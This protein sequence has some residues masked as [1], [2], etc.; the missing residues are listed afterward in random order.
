MYESMSFGD[1]CKKHLILMIIAGSHGGQ[2]SPH[3]GESQ[4][5][6]VQWQGT[7]SVGLQGIRIDN[8]ILQICSKIIHEFRLLGNNDTQAVKTSDSL[9]ARKWGESEEMEIEA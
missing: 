2:S 1:F 5:L 4:P 6:S 3:I 7:L 8:G 9:A